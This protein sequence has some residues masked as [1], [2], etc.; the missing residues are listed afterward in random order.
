LAAAASLL[1]YISITPQQPEYT[2]AEIALAQQELEVALSYV[3]KYSITT[4]TEVNQLL[5]NTSTRAIYK[6]MLYPIVEKNHSSK[7]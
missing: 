5:S 2:E 6:G 4:T 1:L 3:S 7:N